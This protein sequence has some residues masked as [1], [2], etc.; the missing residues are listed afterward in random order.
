M[1]VIKRKE[2]GM[3]FRPPA[4]GAL[5]ERQGRSLST[6]PMI[7][8]LLIATALAFVSIVSSQAHCGTC[9]HKDEKK[10]KCEKKD[11]DCGDKCEKKTEDKK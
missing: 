3:R 4:N 7:K 10:G 2:Q 6:S 11:D 5:T 9:D 8:S 1:Q